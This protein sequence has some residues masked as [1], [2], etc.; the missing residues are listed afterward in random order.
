V[1]VHWLSFALSRCV[2]LL[3]DYSVC[4]AKLLTM[5]GIDEFDVFMD[6][7]NR[8][9]SMKMMIDTA[10]LSDR[11]QFILI[12]PQDMTNV[13]VSGSVKVHRMTDPERGNGTLSFGS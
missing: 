12:T 6:A 2:D 1:G 10:N 7:V 8:R 4:Y 13:T 5:G 9:I 11:K 3:P